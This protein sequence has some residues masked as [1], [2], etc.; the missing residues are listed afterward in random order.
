LKSVGVQPLSSSTLSDVLV[1]HA[2]RYPLWGLDDLYKL[3]HQ[4]SMGSEHAL[5]EETKAR[6]FLLHELAAMGP[7]S[8][9]PLL[10][11][12]SGAGAIVRVHLRPFASLGLDPE[13]L[14]QAFVRTAREYHGTPDRVE[15]GL[16][17]AAHL[18]RERRLSFGESDVRL[19]LLRMKDAGFPAA[20]HSAAFRSHY[21]PAYRVVARAFLPVDLAGAAR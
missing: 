2:V 11:P 19:L 8:D 7:G 21:K 5:T 17:D 13:V 4:A 6:S 10:D 9:E 14:A 18:G 1:A 12:I 20:H 15:A 16:E 3:V